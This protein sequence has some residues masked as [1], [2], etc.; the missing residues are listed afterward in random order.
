MEKFIVFTSGAQNFAITDHSDR[1]N[2]M[3][4]SQLEFPDTSF[5]IY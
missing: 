2:I 5:L 3:M 1:K 4:E